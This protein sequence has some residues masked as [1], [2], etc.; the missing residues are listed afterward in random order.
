MVGSHLADYILAEQSDWE[1][2]GLKRWRSNTE[3]IEGIRD[4]IQLIDCDLRDP[5]RINDVIKKI[6]P[7]YI[8]H[9]A[10]QSYVPES[11]QSPQTTLLDNVQMQLN[12]FEAVRRN[13]IDPRIQIALSSEEYGR[14]FDH[15]LPINELN[16]F[17]PMSPYAVSK[18]TQDMLAYQY[19]ESYGMKVIRTRAFN[20]EGP[21]RGEVF[22]TS[23]FARQ[24]A[25][26]EYGLKPP[27]IRVGNLN[28]KRD[29][30][31]VRDMVVAYW[32][33]LEHC[34]PG[35]DYVL[36]SGTSRSVK[37]LLNFL[38]SLTDVSIEVKQDEA[39]LRPSDVPVL[40]GDSTKFR[41]KSGW[42]QKYKF[43][44]T[45]KDTLNYW[46]Q[47]VGRQCSNAEQTGLNKTANSNALNHFQKEYK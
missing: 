3:N 30:T 35:E 14:V 40:V 1:V 17:R 43:E 38:L 18:I 29:W 16:P 26:I 22:V 39:R 32:L 21:R 15:E 28:A 13:E 24:I 47:M 8:F 33:A 34:N 42:E 20:H 4:Q 37:E 41:Q 45:M 23:N 36:A 5:G 11:W 12:L 10:A 44:D 6:K 7:D 27:E 19:Y 31:D 2:Y 9:L 46:R 25:E